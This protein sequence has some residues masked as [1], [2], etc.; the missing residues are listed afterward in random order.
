MA[1]PVDRRA[2][3]ALV[4]AAAR[5]FL[6]D[7]G[8]RDIARNARYRGG[9]LDLVMLD[10]GVRG[11]PCLVFVEVRYRNTAGFGGGAMS[12]DPRKQRRLVHAA[13]LFLAGNRQFAKAPC[14]FDVVVA[15][16]DPTRPALQWL[17]DAFRADDASA[18]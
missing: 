1:D 9:E 12:I 6:L 13:Q 4:E 15:D 11:A 18:V 17:R 14:R 2:R 7:A 5:R 3:G 8:L 16:G 10:P